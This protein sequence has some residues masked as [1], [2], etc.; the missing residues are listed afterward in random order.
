MPEPRIKRSRLEAVRGLF[1]E[2]P[3]GGSPFPTLYLASVQ[4]RLALAE[5]LNNLPPEQKQWATALWKAC[6]YTLSRLREVVVRRRY[7]DWLRQTFANLPCDERYYWTHF[8]GLAIKDFHADV[9][10]LLDA[11]APMIILIDG[12]IKK[13]DRKRLPYFSWLEKKEG[14]NAGSYRKNL[15]LDLKEAVDAT[16][17]WLPHV[18]EIRHIL[19]HRKHSRLIFS[20]PQDGFLFQLSNDGEAPDVPIVTHPVLLKTEYTNVADFELY[21]SWVLA[22]VIY[23]LDKIG[24]LI[25]ERERFKIFEDRLKKI[26]YGDLERG[27]V[28]VLVEWPPVA[29]DVDRLLR[30]LQK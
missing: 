15:E 3:H 13:C 21:S 10:S 16:V 1:E 28:P 12:Q 8:A 26:G 24:R 27:K 29:L 9:A 22:E 17:E 18:R 2:P 25:A 23:F 4:V 5:S 30:R 19:I 6:G 20:G 7:L 14:Q 11:V